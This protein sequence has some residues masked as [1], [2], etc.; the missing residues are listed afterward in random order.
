VALVRIL[1]S[2]VASLCEKEL[3]KVEAKTFV[4]SGVDLIEQTWPCWYRIFVR[5]AERGTGLRWYRLNST[6]LSVLRMRPS[7]GKATTIT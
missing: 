2:V 3:R 7:A 6:A 5:C 1:D 4:S